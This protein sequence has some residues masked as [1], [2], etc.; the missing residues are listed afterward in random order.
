MEKV[1]YNSPI[2][3]LLI[4][5]E[6]GKIN[7]VASSFSKE[8]NIITETNEPVLIECIKQLSEYFLGQ[9]KIF[10]ID[11]DTKGSAFEQSVW[12]E[13]INIPYAQTR[14]YGQIASLIG[15]PKASRAVGG[16]CHKNPIMI[17]I[18]CH[19]VISS[20][21]SLGGFGGGIE[22]KKILLENERKYVC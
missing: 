15:S 17:I 20:N 7:G 14:S 9:R 4:T 22:M 6:N 18:P 5:S 2:G 21:G 11:I 19:R 10:D 13:L 8:E 3:A 12:A 1:I 16:A